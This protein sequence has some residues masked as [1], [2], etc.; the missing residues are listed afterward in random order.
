MVTPTNV[1]I[2]EQGGKPMFAVIP[3]EDYLLA[4]N[5]PVVKKVR[6][7]QG[8]RIPN[9]VVKLMFDQKITLVRAWREYLGLTQDEVAEKMGIT[10]SALAQMETSTK[11]RKATRQ[12]L[13]DALG[14]NVEQL[15]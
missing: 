6:I 10:Q 8:D 4:F 15:I 11:P 14:I 12:K 3:Y 7:P 2:I 1:Q 13:A 5:P 9:D